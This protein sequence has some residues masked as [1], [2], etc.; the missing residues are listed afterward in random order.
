MT[1]TSEELKTRRADLVTALRS[2]DYKQGTGVLRSGDKF[3]CLGVACD[4]FDPKQWTRTEA[5]G[6]TYAETYGPTHSINMLP[7]DVKDY[8]GFATDGGGF[9]LSYEVPYAA[10]LRKAGSRYPAAPV[11]ALWRA[12]DVAGL[13][14]GQI[15]DI[16]EAEPEGLFVG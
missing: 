10:Q 5:Y 9:D 6:G 8:Y 11:A 13:T 4:R 12:N 7:D 1:A 2:G 16:I 14:F 15:A 3:C